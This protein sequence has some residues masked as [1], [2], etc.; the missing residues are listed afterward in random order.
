VALLGT[1]VQEVFDSFFAKCPETDFTGK[2]TLVYQLFKSGIAHCYKD[3]SESL[4]YSFDNTAYTG[5][6][7][8]TIGLDTIELIALCMK[9][10]F[11]RR[12]L[13]KYTLVKQHIGTNAFNKLPDIKGSADTAT[14]QYDNLTDEIEDFKQDFYPY[15]K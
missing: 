6:F 15:D 9:R 10:E 4:E 8:Y 13:D 3:V 14:S 5:N 12:S 2:E 7:T 1:D 11:S